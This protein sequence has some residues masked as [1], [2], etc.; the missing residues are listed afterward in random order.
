MSRWEKLG[1]VVL[2]CLM[3]AIAWLGA[4]MVTRMP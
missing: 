2:F 3:G 4:V 1:C